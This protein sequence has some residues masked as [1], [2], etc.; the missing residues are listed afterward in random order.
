MRPTWRKELTGPTL[1]AFRR[2]TPLTDN[3]F[4]SL[5][6]DTTIMLFLHKSLPSFRLAARSSDASTLPEEIQNPFP[7]ILFSAPGGSGGGNPSGT[8][9]GEEIRDESGL[10][11]GAGVSAE[12]AQVAAGGQGTDIMEGGTDAGGTD[13]GANMGGPGDTGGI[14]VKALQEKPAEEDQYDQPGLDEDAE[15]SKSPS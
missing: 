7:D 9:E 12:D 2:N 5:Q 14:D 1:A 6:P 11:S 8:D 10:G 15:A 3:P 4:F 13:F